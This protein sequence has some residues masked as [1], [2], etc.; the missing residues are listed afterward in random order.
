MTTTP[1]NYPL[2]MELKVLAYQA[3]PAVFGVS[4]ES[5]AALVKE[6]EDLR[7]TL[8]QTHK[9]LDE[10]LLYLVWRR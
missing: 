4:A 10:A 5:H 8:G 1:L 7:E 2:H 3:T 6:V 9:T